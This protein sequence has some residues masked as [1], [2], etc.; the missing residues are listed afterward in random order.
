[1][2]SCHKYIDA[3]ETG[4]LFSNECRTIIAPGSNV[5]CICIELG[6]TQA[7]HEE[8]SNFGSCST[9]CNAKPL[10]GI[11]F[12]MH[13]KTCCLTCCRDTCPIAI[14]RT[15]CQRTIKIGCCVVKNK[16]C[17]KLLIEHLMN[18][19]WAAWMCSTSIL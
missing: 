14:N 10:F 3:I 11:R 8:L 5:S 9:N 7:F 12:R 15:I 1:M 19:F 16:T 2:L 18:S 6:N 4:T 13:K 17:T